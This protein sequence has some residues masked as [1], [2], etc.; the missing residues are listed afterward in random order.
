MRRRG[1]EI[2]EVVFIQ[3][4]EETGFFFFFFFFF[5]VPQDQGAVIKE[6]QPKE[7]RACFCFLDKE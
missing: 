7:L 1:G 2:G 6:G 4:V 5:F 3:S